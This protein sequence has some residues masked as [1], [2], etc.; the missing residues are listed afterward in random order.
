VQSSSRMMWQ[1][2][3]LVPSHAKVKLACDTRKLSLRYGSKNDH[4]PIKAR[5]SNKPK[6][7]VGL[8]CS[9]SLV[10]LSFH[11]KGW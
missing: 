2:S 1:N 3:L 9:Y 4:G 5:Y 7:R 8:L 6:V 10:L 11:F